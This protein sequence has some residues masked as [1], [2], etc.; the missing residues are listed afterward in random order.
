MAAD[1]SRLRCEEVTIYFSGH[2]TQLPEL[3]RGSEEDGKDE[4]IV[5]TDG[6]IRDDEL[7]AALARFPPACAVVCVFDCCNSSTM[8]DAPLLECSP[9]RARE[10][11]LICVA[12]ALDGTPAFQSR[13]RGRFTVHLERKARRRRRLKAKHLHRKAV[14]SATVTV[15][16]VAITPDTSIWRHHSA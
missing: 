13:G 6:H 12:A 9:S 7:A 4:A 11:P 14:G 2:G 5:C 15:S 8:I 3:I 1:A 10:A 16:G